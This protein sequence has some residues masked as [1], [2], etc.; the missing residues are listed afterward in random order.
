MQR[1]GGI[2]RYYVELM[3]EY[4]RLNQEFELPVNFSNNIYLHDT[5]HTHTYGDFRVLNRAFMLLSK[6][7]SKK[8][9][10]KGEYDIFHPTY[11]DPY[12]TSIVKTP[13]VIT[14]YDMIH[15]KLSDMKNLKNPTLRWKRESVLGA[16]RILAIS[17]NTKNDIIDIYGVDESKIDVVYLSSSL[18]KTHAIPNIS[19]PK[20]YLLFVGNRGDYKNFDR[21]LEATAPLLKEDKRLYVVCA[22]GGEFSKKELYTISHLKI[23]RKVLFVDINNRALS[24]LYQNALLFV[25]P[26]LYEGFGIPVLEAMNCDCPMALSE[27]SSLPEIAGNAA[28][29][30]DPKSTDHMC[31]IIRNTIYDRDKMNRLV[32]LGRKK[33]DEF[34][35]KN[36]A[37]QTLESYRK[38]L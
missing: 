12:F 5:K 18:Q 6:R 2:S 38:A 19:L 23:D 13:Y 7:S 8:H 17:E 15:E 34:C 10:L 36:T 9:L 16:S 11:Y 4:K 27:T 22:G 25:F 24:Y 33:R 35:W 30:F 32:E 21:F 37:R 28:V 29:Y 3:Q 14:V 26:S 20:K 1:Y 31:T